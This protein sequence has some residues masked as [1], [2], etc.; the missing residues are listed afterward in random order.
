MA[1]NL[2]LIAPETIGGKVYCENCNVYY[3]A[4]YHK[5]DNLICPYCLLDNVYGRYVGKP[6]FTSIEEVKE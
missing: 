1:D 6:A 2:T 3:L 4:I 5:G